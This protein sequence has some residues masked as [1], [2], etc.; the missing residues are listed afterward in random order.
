MSY[1]EGTATSIGHLLVQFFDFAGSNGWSIDEDIATDSQ[2]PKRGTIHHPLGN[3]YYHFDFSDGQTG[4]GT[5]TNYISTGYTPLAIP[6]DQPGLFYYGHPV[7][8]VAGAIAAFWFFESDTY[9]HVVFK[10]A[11][12]NYRHFHIGLLSKL[13]NW[14][15]GDYLTGHFVDAVNN[16]SPTYFSH[17]LPFDGADTNS[18]NTMKGTVVYAKKNSG[19]GFD[20]APE[21]A[22]KWY[23]ACPGRGAYPDL[24][25]TL[26]GEALVTAVRGGIHSPISTIG[27]SVLTGESPLVPI[28]FFAGNNNVSPNRYMLLGAFPDIRTVNIKE[29]SAAEEYV[30]GADTWMAFPVGRRGSEVGEEQ[31]RYWGYAY[32][33]VIA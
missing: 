1:L 26:V 3:T 2:D 29:L 32:K 27:P 33:K 30:S 19:T 10:N 28:Q 9:L 7:T 25:G 24:D 13:G 23:V 17:S 20:L 22:T 31:T 14:T 5:L 11:A 18:A 12:G 15:G 4:D 8:H 16:Q 6:T 21:L